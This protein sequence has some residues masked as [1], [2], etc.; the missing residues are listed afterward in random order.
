MSAEEIRSKRFGGP[1]RAAYARTH[2]KEIFAKEDHAMFF[3]KD[4]EFAR[5]FDVSRHTIYKIRD[6]LGIAPR[7][8]R[9]LKRLKEL[10]LRKY[11][12]KDLAKKLNLKYQNLYKII[13]ENEL[14]TKPDTLPI[15]FLKEYQRR[16]KRARIRGKK[17]DPD[18]FSGNPEESDSD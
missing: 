13:L 8:K 5:L 11:T 15:E 3:A 16:K 7:S 10:D 4:I 6:E 9:V 1:E 18:L 14:E 17:P 12:I 2:M